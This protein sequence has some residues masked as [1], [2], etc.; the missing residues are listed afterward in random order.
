MNKLLTIINNDHNNSGCI[1][2]WTGSSCWQLCCH[3]GMNACM[4]LHSA[5]CSRDF[6]V[7][8][9]ADLHCHKVRAAWYNTWLHGELTPKLFSFLFY[10]SLWCGKVG[11]PA[12]QLWQI[13]IVMKSG[14]PVSD[15]CC[16]LH[17]RCCVSNKLW[18]L[19][20]RPA[21]LCRECLEC[22]SGVACCVIAIL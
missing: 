22:L 3:E 5:S 20:A 15:G 21:M 7:I 1:E 14:Q 2:A 17:V 10:C 8:C 19:P 11:K 4:V 16:M 13:C 9:W 18:A 6:G 12:T